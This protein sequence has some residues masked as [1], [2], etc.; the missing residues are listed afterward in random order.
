MIKALS[1]LI[2]NGRLPLGTRLVHRA[3]SRDRDV[4][5]VVTAEGIRVGNTVYASPSGAAKV[6]KG[7]A[8]NGWVWWRLESSGEP[9]ASLRGK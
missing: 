7:V 5:G 1:E 4:T 9:L 2:E 6:M 8:A 3:R